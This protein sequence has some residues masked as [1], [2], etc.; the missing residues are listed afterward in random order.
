MPKPNALTQA[1][2]QPAAN[3]VELPMKAAAARSR[4]GRVLVGGHFAPQVQTQL[5]IMAAEER[6][7]AQ[8]LLAEALNM[9]FAKRGKPEIADF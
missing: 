4:E 9:L 2:S 8:A 3:V 7:T 5:K 1:L 6:T